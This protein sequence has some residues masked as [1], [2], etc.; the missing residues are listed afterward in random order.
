MR[1]LSEGSEEKH[2]ANPLCSAPIVGFSAP[3]NYG[4]VKIIRFSFEVVLRTMKHTMIYSGSGPS[5]E[6]IAMRS[7]V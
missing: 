5:S 2:V 4:V 3:T 1:E 7:T 6:V